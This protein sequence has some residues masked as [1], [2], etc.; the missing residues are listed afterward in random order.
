M[1]S[2]A[3]HGALWATTGAAWRRIFALLAA[4]CAWLPA[5]A[6]QACPVCFSQVNE[7]VLQTYYLTAAFMTLLPAAIVAA[8]GAWVYRRRAAGDAAPR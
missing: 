6:A 8:I 2:A 4:S 1:K 7:N 3:T 5:P